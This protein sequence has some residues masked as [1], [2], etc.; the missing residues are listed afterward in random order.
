ML[1]MEGSCN[2]EPSVPHAPLYKRGWTLQERA[3]STR[4]LH[5]G[6]QLYW[7][8]MTSKASE[9]FPSL[10][11][12]DRK[13]LDSTWRNPVQGLKRVVSDADLFRAF[14]SVENPRPPPPIHSRHLRHHRQPRLDY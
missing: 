3:L 2:F 11:I 4:T 9:A 7:E 8:C 10:H 1:K 13:M 12:Q 14:S 5:C 6:K